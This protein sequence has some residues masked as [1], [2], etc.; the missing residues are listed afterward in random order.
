MCI[1]DSSNTGLLGHF[2]GMLTDSRNFLSF[3]RHEYFRRVLCNLL[4]GQMERGELPDDAGLVGA[5]VRRIAFA[6]ARDYF[7]LELNPPY[8]GA[9]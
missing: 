4:G 9:G 5:M 1:R 3:A 8:A 2:V 6:N 7:A